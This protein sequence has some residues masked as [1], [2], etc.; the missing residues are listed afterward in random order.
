MFIASIHSRARIA[1]DQHCPYACRIAKSNQISWYLQEDALK[2]GYHLCTHCSAVYQAYREE[3][4]QLEIYVSLHDM[5]L[6]W[7]DH[8]LKVHTSCSDWII[9]PHGNE[10]IT[11]FHKNTFQ[12]LHPPKDTPFPGYHS[13][14][15]LRRSLLEYLKCI[16][17]HDL[18]RKRSPL[19]IIS[20]DQPAKR[21]YGVHYGKAKRKELNRIRKKQHLQHVRRVQTLINS[22]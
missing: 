4:P 1:H 7:E 3:R 2:A 11:L 19:D 14:H 20:D 21:K 13:Q 16:H 5:S 22:L 12:P 6:I 8:L 17:H 15:V 18:Y 9:A 10:S